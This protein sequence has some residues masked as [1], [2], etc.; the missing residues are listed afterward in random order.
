MDLE[1]LTSP[2]VFVS[3]A[4]INPNASALVKKV[5]VS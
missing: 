3:S 1:M 2:N 4:L 5:F